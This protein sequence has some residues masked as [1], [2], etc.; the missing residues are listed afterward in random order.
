MT[1][2]T[3]EAFDARLAAGL[4]HPD[5]S[6]ARV[7]AGLRER[8]KTE[9]R[10]VERRGS[11][12][13]ACVA[14][15]LVLMSAGAFYAL[16]NL[17]AG[18]PDA[19]REIAGE[20]EE[21]EEKGERAPDKPPGP[22]RYFQSSLAF[23]IFERDPWLGHYEELGRTP[24]PYAKG[25]RIPFGT[26]WHV[27][28]FA[29]VDAQ[30]AP[31]YAAEV[32]ALRVPRLVLCDT[33]EKDVRFL[34]HLGEAPDLR[35]LALAGGDAETMR[36]LKRLQGLRALDVPLSETNADLL[37]RLS[38]LKHL[39]TLRLHGKSAARLGADVL[40]AVGQL[41]EL[42]ELTLE[43]FNAK[44]E[45]WSALEGLTNLRRLRVSDSP[46]D[47]AS[48]K[49]FAGL[50]R[51]EELAL[52]E[53]R[54][55][56]AELE[57]LRGLKLKRFRCGEFILG[58]DYGEEKLTNPI[59]TNWPSPPVARPVHA[60]VTAETR[61][62]WEAEILRLADPEF[63]IRRQAERALAL[64]GAAA[65]GTL[66]QALSRELALGERGDLERIAALRRTLP[67]LIDGDRARLDAE[68]LAR[69]ERAKRTRT[70]GA[71]PIDPVLRERLTR[72]ITFEHVDK[73]LRDSLRV[74]SAHCGVPI[75]VDPEVLA[76]LPGNEPVINLRVADMSSELALE[77]V[78]RLAE[79]DYVPFEDAV[80]VVRKIPAS[81]ILPVTL[82][83][84]APQN[85]PTWDEMEL[86]VVAKALA[87]LPLGV[88]HRGPDQSCVRI[89]YEEALQ[90][91]VD[92]VTACTSPEEAIMIEE[93][94]AQWLGPKEVPPPAAPEWVEEIERKLAQK[95]SLEFQETPALEALEFVRNLAKL[96]INALA[97]PEAQ[98]PVSLRVKDV[99]VR[100]ILGEIAKAVKARVLV[101]DGVLNLAKENEPR[102]S[103]VYWACWDLSARARGD[104]TAMALRARLDAL[105]VMA[106]AEPACLRGRWIA[107]LDFFTIRRIEALLKQAAET[108]AL[109]E[110]DPPLPWE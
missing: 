44:A 58:P 62:R 110:S 81:P 88:D 16:L 84:P 83:L 52:T 41:T 51:L 12:T 106:G 65:I 69:F 91:R 39:R 14:A 59:F 77:W 71:V 90:V 107:L 8:L 68:R 49:H 75:F 96:R 56:E 63:E 10:S 64:Q 22:A 25:V 108:G 87:E 97:D 61:E 103:P 15:A 89:G 43:Y 30:S 9:P 86:L 20:D 4:A 78:L 105:A 66:K 94:L 2:E 24:S 57:P 102:P 1:T 17:G 40:R 55:T 70:L 34:R 21:K 33:D 95:V 76:S 42:E 101:R 19:P 80:A 27:E 37:K 36:E 29:Q 74:I 3:D 48:L 35:S 18:T 104:V 23:R 11:W 79:L 28:P 45:D 73:A 92:S 72:R 31:A 50:S 7:L 85:G 26:V 5:G 46:M 93:F 47:G 54:V 13:Q 99:P 53:A 38:D 67:L 32:V 82:T 109:P 100:Q 60:E 98:V 6:E